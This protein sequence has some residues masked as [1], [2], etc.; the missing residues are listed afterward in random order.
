MTDLNVI[1]FKDKEK[2]PM[3][4]FIQDIAKHSPIKKPMLMF[5]L[6]EDNQPVCHIVGPSAAQIAL[7]K[8]HFDQA[9]NSLI[10]RFM[11]QEE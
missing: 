10:E 9:A 1:E 5:G 2:T 3:D 8:W 6:T 4:E 7:I 11:Q